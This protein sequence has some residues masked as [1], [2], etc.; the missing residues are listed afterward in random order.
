M[1]LSASSSSQ[2][3]TRLLP[4]SF[5]SGFVAIGGDTMNFSDM[6]SSTTYSS[7]VTVNDLPVNMTLPFSGTLFSI[8]GGSRSFGPPVG[9]LIFAHESTKSVAITVSPRLPDM[10]L[11]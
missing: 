4:L 7:K 8:T 3:T 2:V 11:P 10:Y 1:V 5:T 6:R 9:A